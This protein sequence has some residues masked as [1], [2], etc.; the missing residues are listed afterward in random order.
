MAWNGIAISGK[1]LGKNVEGVVVILF[2]VL[3]KP[4]TGDNWQIPSVLAGLHE[5]CFHEN[6]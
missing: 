1:F 2:D 3:S 4:L 6:L 5:V